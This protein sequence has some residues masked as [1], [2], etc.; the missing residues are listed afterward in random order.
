MLKAHSS[1]F[2]LCVIVIY[3]NCRPYLC[4]LCIWSAVTAGLWMFLDQ[5]M[6]KGRE[7]GSQC[8]FPG[9]RSGPKAWDLT[10]SD[11]LPL[12]QST[13]N[14]QLQLWSESEMGSLKIAVHMLCCVMARGPSPARWEQMNNSSSAAVRWA[15]VT[16]PS[17][18]KTWGG[19][20]LLIGQTLIGWP[21]KIRRAPWS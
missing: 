12:F 8:L 19:G 18:E 6:E 9:W 15:Q 7:G 1:C 14:Q 10:L 20:K 4:S 5:G 21:G 13:S 16:V 3:S 11:L 2:Y 17:A